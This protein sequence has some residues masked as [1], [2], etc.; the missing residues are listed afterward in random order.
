MNKLICLPHF[1]SLG[2]LRI[3][4]SAKCR[5]PNIR[6]LFGWFIAPKLVRIEVITITNVLHVCQFLGL[7]LL[8]GN[9]FLFG[10]FDAIYSIRLN[11]EYLNN[12]CTRE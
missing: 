7:Q 5:L 12:I 11:T 4:Y 1:I 8:F 10:K 9:S 2:L 3:L 6:Q